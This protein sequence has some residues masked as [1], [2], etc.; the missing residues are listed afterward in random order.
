MST[1]QS[2]W[3][4]PTSTLAPLST[5]LERELAKLHASARVTVADY[6]EIDR[7]VLADDS[8]WRRAAPP[9]TVL[10]PDGHDLLAPVY[11]RPLS[12]GDEDRE[13][14][15]QHAVARAGA[16]LDRVARV[17][18]R[19]FVTN[20]AWPPRS[21]LGLLEADPRR[22][23]GQL[24]ARYNA[25]LAAEAARW[26][27]VHVVDWAGLVVEIGYAQAHDARLFAHAR[28][29][30]G[31]R[32]LA[33]LAQGLA[34]AIAAA[35]RPPRKCVVLDLDGT[36]WG[37]VLG[38]DGVGGIRL[39]GEGVGAAYL[40]FQRE[41]LE[42]RSRGVLLAI[43]SKNDPEQALA[44]IDEH[45]EMALR[46]DAFAAIR[47]GWG[48]KTEAIAAIAEEL[49]FAT[50]ALVFVD[51]SPHERELVRALL[52]EVAVVD[53]PA[54]PAD[55]VSALRAAPAL[56][57]LAVTDDDRGRAERVVAER[58]RVE[59][60]ARTGSLE[61]FL[62]GLEQR[63]TVAPVG[64]ATLAR[65]AQLC[66]RTNQF[67]LTLARHDQAALAGLLDRGAIGL[68]LSARDR[69]GDHG[70][71]AF[72]LARPCHQEDQEAA[73]EWRVDT[74]V[75]SCR[76]IGRGLESA[77]LVELARAAAERGARTLVG[78]HRPG[79]RNAVCADLLARHGFEPRGDGDQAVDLERPPRG[80]AVPAW[81]AVERSRA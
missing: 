9:V 57:V 59:L 21:A 52:P 11:E 1:P 16:L 23:L 13:A 26:P 49:G 81:V 6:G 35:E 25:A 68:V 69:L 5:A 37:G 17:S 7:L 39:G 53:L 67:N 2:I 56:D 12:T 24:A 76:V 45:P 75:M 58:A 31:A 78:A 33:A 80:L 50:D 14:A 72:G 42:L 60:R 36:L 27:N 73:G 30:L 4:L 15:L 63:A 29:R 74:F 3:V 64:P 40:A 65:A 54:D 46:R 44:A 22:S 20:A 47:I 62:A 66:A 18:R 8:A 43:A 71:I 10:V 48:P 34:R 61:E 41:L 32:G 51:D 38:E 79:P 19:V 28:M 77:L 55:F 70:V